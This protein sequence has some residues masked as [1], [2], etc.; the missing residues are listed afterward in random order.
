M[1]YIVSA[2]DST[3]VLKTDRFRVCFRRCT[4]DFFIFVP[5]TTITPRKMKSNSKQAKEKN[6]SNDDYL[7]PPLPARFS[8]PQTMKIDSAWETAELNYNHHFLYFLWFGNAFNYSALVSFFANFWQLNKFCN[9]YI[10][11]IFIL[12]TCAESIANRW[13]NVAFKKRI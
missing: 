4:S 3:Y 7:F 12:M 6:W 2:I 8:L 10:S 1:R 11:M 9:H 5:V 13:T